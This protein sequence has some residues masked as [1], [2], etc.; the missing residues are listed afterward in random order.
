MSETLADF[1]MRRAVC[2]RPDDTLE[3]ALQ[4]LRAA[5]SQ[6]VLVMGNDGV[7]LMALMAESLPRLWLEGMALTTP[8]REVVGLTP[9]VQP[10]T[11]CRRAA[12]EG[13]I[14]LEPERVLVVQDEEGALLGV[15][16][17]EDFCRQLGM[18]RVSDAQKL[19]ESLQDS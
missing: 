13:L 9:C 19:L 4:E 3:C 5:P 2:L 10:I 11:A 14:S 17:E 8:L 15:L 6:A 1:V 12:V 16:D 18:Q 7:P